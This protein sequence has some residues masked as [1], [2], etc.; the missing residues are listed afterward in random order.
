[1]ASSHR[2]A[3]TTIRPRFGDTGPGG[4]VSGGEPGGGVSGGEPGGGGGGGGVAAES[5]VCSS[6]IVISGVRTGRR[7]RGLA[8]PS[9][10]VRLSGFRRSD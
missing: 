3:S 4:G 10:P 7:V 5:G 1:M 9:M 6:V 2:Y 8:G